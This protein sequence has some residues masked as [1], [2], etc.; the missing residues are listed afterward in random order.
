ML[1]KIYRCGFALLCFFAANSRL[2]AREQQLT[3]TARPAIDLELLSRGNPLSPLIWKNFRQ[4]PIPPVDQK[5]G[6]K[7]SSYTKQGKLAPSLSEFLK[8]VVEN[9]LALQAAR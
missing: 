3:E 1:Q 9:N 2:F 6:P 5:N 8:L 4:A 7:V